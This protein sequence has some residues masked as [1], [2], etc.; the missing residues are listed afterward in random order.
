MSFSVLG[1]SVPFFLTFSG[2]CA[3]LIAFLVAL[4]FIYHYALSAKGAICL[5]LLTWAILVVPDGR[6]HILEWAQSGY[7]IFMGTLFAFTLHGLAGSL[8]RSAVFGIAKASGVFRWI[9]S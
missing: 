4:F 9:F 2:G 3:F 5:S 6:L 1:K 8:L 7:M